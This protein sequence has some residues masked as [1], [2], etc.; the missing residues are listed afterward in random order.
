MSET[1]ATL[2]SSYQPLFLATASCEIFNLKPGV[3]VT[4]ESPMKLL[5][6]ASLLADIDNRRAV[7]DF[8]PYKN[9]IA[10]YFTISYTLPGY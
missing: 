3:D 5:S 9:L 7:S 8:Q 2:P 4:A 10:V 1:I 6:K